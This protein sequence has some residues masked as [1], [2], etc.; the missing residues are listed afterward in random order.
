MPASMRAAMLAAAAATVATV[1]TV[2]TATAAT[3]TVAT[4]T[5][6]NYWR[7]F[8][9]D[10]SLYPAPSRIPPPAKGGTAGMNPALLIK[11]GMNG[12]R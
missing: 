4:A 9:G 3:A 8:K 6:S 7:L 2:A 10:G 5:A 11:C 1:A 12:L